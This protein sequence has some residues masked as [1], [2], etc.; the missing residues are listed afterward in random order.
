MQ[1]ETNMVVD[2]TEEVVATPA[3]ETTEEM[4]TEEAVTE[5][6]SSEEVA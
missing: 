5:E 6:A 3:E 2:A 4:A 1:D